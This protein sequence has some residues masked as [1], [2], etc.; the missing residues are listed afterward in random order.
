MTDRV[1]FTPSAGMHHNRQVF[2][3]Y[4]VLLRNCAEQFD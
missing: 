1:V 3:V 4:G 2:R